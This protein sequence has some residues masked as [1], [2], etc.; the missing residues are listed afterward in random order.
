M[1]ASLLPLLKPL[2]PRNRTTSNRFINN[3]QQEALLLLLLLPWVAVPRLC[4]AVL[5]PPLPLHLLVEEEEDLE[6]PLLPLL[7]EEAVA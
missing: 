4:L 6:V 7:E 1:L 2:W 3:L 5:L